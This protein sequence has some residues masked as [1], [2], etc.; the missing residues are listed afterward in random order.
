[1]ERTNLFIQTTSK[2]FWEEPE[3]TSLEDLHLEEF[4]IRR[5][6][7]TFTRLEKSGAV[8]FTVRTFTTPLVELG[9]EELRALRSQIWG[10]EEDIKEYK[11][12]GI[13]GAKL[14]EWCEGR[15]GKREETKIMRSSGIEKCPM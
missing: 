8:L 9:D 14:E 3:S 6:R 4:T 10:W 2:L 12:W 11:G 1:M 15:L 13:W 7:Q 5:E